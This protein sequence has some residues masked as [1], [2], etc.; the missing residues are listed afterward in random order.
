[1]ILNKDDEPAYNHI[2]LFIYVAISNFFPLTT[3]TFV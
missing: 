1:M 3:A 2:L